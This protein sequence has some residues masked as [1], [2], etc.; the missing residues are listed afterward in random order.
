M[1]FAAEFPHDVP[2]TIA[3]GV[4]RIT[5]ANP[6]PF[7]GP[8]TN[9]YVLGD[10]AWAIIDPGPN[11][12]AH[13]IAL[14]ACAP[15]ARWCFVTHTH[16]DH[17]PLAMQYCAA[18]GAQPV[19]RAPPGDGRQDLSF[20]PQL[21]PERD[22]DFVA[23]DG[24]RLISIDTPGHASNHVCYFLP[25]RGLLFTG[26]H[27]LDSVSP[28]IL[29]PDG[30]MAAYLDALRRLKGYPLAA[31]APG[32]GRLQTEPQ[33]IIDGLIAHRLEREAKV[34]RELRSLASATTDQLL[35]SVYADVKPEVM[36]LARHS[37]EAHLIKLANERVIA[38]RGDVWHAAS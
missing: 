6:S 32:H 9:S 7:T 20:L 17:S 21:R 27:I 22:Q 16:P 13:L 1:D 30:D 24:T 31:I 2:V 33:K 29:S 8:G 19:G 23:P 18:S 12:P 4:R 25:A 28:V 34:L 26:D 10:P 35:P 37:L 15:R 11:L 36:S 3:P 38:R 5:A 14:L